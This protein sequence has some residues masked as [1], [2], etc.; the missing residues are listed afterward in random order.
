M[1]G[2]YSVRVLAS[3][4]S[5][6]EGV[7]ADVELPDEQLDLRDQRRVGRVHINRSSDRAALS[8]SLP[9]MLTHAAS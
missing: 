1:I 2:A 7:L 3:I 5:P 4:R 8:Y 9:L 6:A